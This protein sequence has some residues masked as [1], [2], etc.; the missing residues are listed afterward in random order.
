MWHEMKEASEEI[1]N[2]INRQL[3]PPALGKSRMI[4]TVYT[5]ALRR[6]QYLLVFYDNEPKPIRWT[7]IPMPDAEF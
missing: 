1:Q 4:H 7:L 3:S 2:I 5:G 6:G